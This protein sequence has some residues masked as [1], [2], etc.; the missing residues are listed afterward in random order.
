LP[1][2]RAQFYEA[3]SDPLGL[4]EFMGK[5]ILYLLQLLR[6]SGSHAN[7]PSF[8]GGNIHTVP[9][10]IKIKNRLIEREAVENGQSCGKCRKNRGS[11]A[12]AVGSVPTLNRG[13]G[14]DAAP[15]TKTIDN[16][17]GNRYFAGLFAGV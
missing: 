11:T 17:E 10:R 2:A 7:A 12:L 16:K 14:L 15:E 8:D 5:F 1:E 4:G 6:E 13:S 9:P 3:I